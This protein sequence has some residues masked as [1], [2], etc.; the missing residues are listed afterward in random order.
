M[1][2]PSLFLGMVLVEEVSATRPPEERS[3]L[4]TDSLPQADHSSRPSL[5]R[6]VS[7]YSRHYAI[8]VQLA[9]RS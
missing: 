9:L 1:R 5:R 7:A 8:G 2:W 6:P 4:L 3:W